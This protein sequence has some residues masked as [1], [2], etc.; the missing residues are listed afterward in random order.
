MYCK[1]SNEQ[2]VNI[3]RIQSFRLNLTQP[4]DET[5]NQE[6]YR[7]QGLGRVFP[8]QAPRA[9]RSTLTAFGFDL[10]ESPVCVFDFP[11]KS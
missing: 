10:P 4:V 3:P 9:F 11:G 5:V 1:I 2:K 7:R 8:L 6:E